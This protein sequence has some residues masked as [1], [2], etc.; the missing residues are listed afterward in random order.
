MVLSPT[1]RS[2]NDA[3][4]VAQQ[5][6]QRLRRVIDHHDLLAGVEH[7][8]LLDRQHD[9]GHLVAVAVMDHGHQKYSALR[10]LGL[11]APVVSADSWMISASTSS[12]RAL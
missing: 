8:L 1:L 4:F 10:T 9:V 6:T 2:V 7:G 3:G 5:M 12:R 11:V